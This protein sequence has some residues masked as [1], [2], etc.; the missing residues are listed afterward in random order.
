MN[1]HGRWM[2]ILAGVLLTLGL[3]YGQKNNSAE[4]LLQSGIKKEVVDGD[5]K[6]AIEI[7]KQAVARGGSNR[8]I[9][10]QALVQMG[11]AYEKLGA[12]EAKDAYSRVLREYSDQ[13]EMAAEAR[14]RLAVIERHSPAAP[15]AEPQGVVLR[16]V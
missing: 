10:A 12:A 6:G 13:Q 2:L 9:T 11:K 3:S 8:A 5:L 1:I 15:A 7:Y 14:A 16:Q 4:T